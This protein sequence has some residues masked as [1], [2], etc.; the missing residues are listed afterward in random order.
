MSADSP[1]KNCVNTPS[2]IV[3]NTTT[4]FSTPK[5]SA[6]TIAIKN[7]VQITKC[8]QLFFKKDFFSFLSLT[9]DSLDCSLS[10]FLLFFAVFAIFQPISDE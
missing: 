2:I 7:R 5:Y 10:L 4:F 9:R 8:F 6:T 3:T 1:A